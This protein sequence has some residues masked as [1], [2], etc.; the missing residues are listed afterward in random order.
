MLSESSERNMG[1]GSGL[2][3]LPGVTA[4]AIDSS[5]VIAEAVA[6]DTEQDQAEDAQQIGEAPNWGS[7]SENSKSNSKSSSSY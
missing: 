4:E 6:N 7:G 2:I 3:D 5:G 1:T